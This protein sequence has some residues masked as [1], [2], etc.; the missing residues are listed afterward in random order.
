MGSYLLRGF[1]KQMLMNELLPIESWLSWLFMVRGG[2]IR[3]TQETPCL[4]CIGWL[5]P[6][7]RW[8]GPEHLP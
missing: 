2:T 1:C 3:R 4:V 5:M 6:F 7:V 8:E